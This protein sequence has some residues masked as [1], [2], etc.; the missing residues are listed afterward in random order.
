MLIKQPT[1]KHLLLALFLLAGLTGLYGQ[2]TTYTRKEIVE[3]IAYIQDKLVKYHPNLYTYTDPTAVTA[4]FADLTASIPDTVSASMA[5]RLISSISLIVKDGHTY[6]LA[7]QKH[8]EQ[9][10]SSQSV[11]PFQILQQGEALYL[12][13]NFSD[14][15]KIPDGV[16]VVSINGETAADLINLIQNNLSRDGNNTNYPKWVFNSFFPAYYGFLYDFPEVFEIAFEDDAGNTQV[17]KIAGLPNSHIS[18]NRKRKYPSYADQLEGRHQGLQLHIDSSSNVATLR[19]KSFDRALLKKE[20][21]QTFAPT[22]KRYFRTIQEQGIS[23]L[24]VDLRGNQGGDLNY[25]K[26]LLKHLMTEPFQMVEGYSKVNQRNIQSP[27]SR[28]KTVNGPAMGRFLPFKHHFKGQVFTFID[29]GSF[30]CSAIVAN[31]LKKQQR[32]ILMGE[33]TGGSAFTLAGGPNKHLN[34]PN[35]QVQ[36]TLPT[37]QYILQSSTGVEKTGV[38]PDVNLNMRI[39]D[40]INGIDPLQ[41]YVLKT[42]H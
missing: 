19:I 12:A 27:S 3:D 32:G 23:N 11:F 6:I 16:K 15:D 36:V 7:S 8:M 21:Q 42:I 9:F 25:G 24:I 1:L 29:G 14:N 39:T 17:V 30:S 37:L 35:T 22:I 5:Y 40:I 10:Y 20:Y 28:N 38:L 41:E 4:F 18:T 33:E 26:Y 13:R 34:C 31:V 2:A